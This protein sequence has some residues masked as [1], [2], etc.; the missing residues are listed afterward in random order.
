[1]STMGILDERANWQGKV[2]LILGGADGMGRAITVAL[3]TAGV[4][5]AF[6]DI[7]ADA[8][9]ATLELLKPLDRKVLCAA[10]DVRDRAALDAFWADFDRQFKRVDIVVNVVGGV[11]HKAFLDS[12][13]QD[14]DDNIRKNFAYVVQSCH[15]AGTRM[16][17]AGRGG[18]IVNITTIEGYRAAPG[19]SVYAGLKAGVANLARTLGCELAPFGIRV[20]CVA[21]D[22]TPTPG[23]FACIDPVSYDPP[24]AGKSEAEIWKLAEEQARNAIPMGRMG[25]LED[26]E[27]CVLFLAS[28][29][30]TYLT[31]Q[32]LHCDGG[33]M[34]S[35]GWL[36]FPK[37]GFRNR[38]PLSMIDTPAYGA[39]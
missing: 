25:R 3:A 19:F 7:N 1:M 31:G 8:I 13:P 18:S 29:L 27:N 38:V 34:A 39:Q 23:L 37:L 9:K 15:H 22:Q 14:W 28:D 16:K 32:T 33:A 35:A 5:V 2:A 17:A 20:N 36:H 4:D 6:C 12:V 11:R 24:P 30:S 21:P 26:I 10:V